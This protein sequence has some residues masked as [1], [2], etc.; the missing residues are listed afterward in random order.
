MTRLAHKNRISLLAVLLLC[1]S[2][3]VW[4]QGN[5]VHVADHTALDACVA[6]HYNAAALPSTAISAEITRTV[7][8]VSDIVAIA[9]VLPLLPL[10]PPA[11]APPENVF[12]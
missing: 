9:V 6:C 1:L 5:H 3:S 8:E 12:A 7:V 11:R 10:R 2:W 4:L